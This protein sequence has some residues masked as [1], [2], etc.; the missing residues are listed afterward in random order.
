MNV[1][2][3]LILRSIYLRGLVPPI[4]EPRKA[5]RIHQQEEDFQRHAEARNR[6]K[7][8]RGW[9]PIAQKPLRRSLPKPE[10]VRPN[11][12]DFS[13]WEKSDE[14]AIFLAV[15][16]N[17]NAPVAERAGAAEWLAAHVFTHPIQKMN[18][19]RYER[20]IM[21][22]LDGWLDATRD[23][24]VLKPILRRKTVGALMIVADFED[25]PQTRTRE[26]EARRFEKASR[27]PETLL[28]YFR[29]RVQT[30]VLNDLLGPGY[31]GRRK[32]EVTG[33]PIEQTNFDT[34]FWMGS[35]RGSL[36]QASEIDDNPTPG[37][38]DRAK[39]QAFLR[40]NSTLRRP[41]PWLSGD[42]APFS[43]HLIEAADHRSMV[44]SIVN[45]LFDEV[46]GLSRRD[47][48]AW[49]RQRILGESLKEVAERSDADCGVLRLFLRA[50]E[51]H[52]LDESRKAGVEKLRSVY[53]ERLK[54][55]YGV[56][57]MAVSRAD[58]KIRRYLEDVATGKVKP[59]DR[60]YQTAVT[61]ADRQRVWEN[62][63]LAKAHQKVREVS[64]RYERA[65]ARKRQ[66]GDRVDML[67]A[68]LLEAL[69]NLKE[70]SEVK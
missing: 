17:R 65:K 4:R 61:L 52:I 58:A 21:A 3:D 60:H 69:E 14:V 16:C 31:Q 39:V 49:V 53:A 5:I 27:S 35:G 23:P 42:S 30:V 59:G 7:I 29:A 47:A 15:L 45:W 9:D 8:A 36:D 40:F 13:N 64:E 22:E 46:P 32:F 63:E 51:E 6:G 62:S 38:A 37:P 25:L 19:V 68:E 48:E 44:F 33:V 10:I 12:C 50:S 2:D 20:D 70:V 66:P 54:R 34:I 43:K 67:H 41:E 57:R 26:R 11:L 1:T 56:V 24:E 55:T 28:R 18:W